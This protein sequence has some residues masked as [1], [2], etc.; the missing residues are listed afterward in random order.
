MKFKWEHAK[1][2]GYFFRAINR[3]KVEREYWDIVHGQKVLVKRYTPLM[4]KELDTI[5]CTPMTTTTIIDI[6]TSN[7]KVGN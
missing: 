3:C 2:L 6:L 1:D 7:G 4:P 5:P